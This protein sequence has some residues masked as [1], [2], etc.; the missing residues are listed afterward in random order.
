MIERQVSCNTCFSDDGK[1]CGGIPRND[2]TTLLSF[3]ID[4]IL[5]FSPVDKMSGHDQGKIIFNAT[6]SS[7]DL[8]KRKS[9]CNGGTVSTFCLRKH[10][11]AEQKLSG[12]YAEVLCQAAY[13]D[14][15][16]MCVCL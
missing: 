2:H 15:E 5:E 13:Y 9:R 12:S 3:S 11:T 1:E 7:I 8:P 4:K 14:R 6:S 10:F 16:K